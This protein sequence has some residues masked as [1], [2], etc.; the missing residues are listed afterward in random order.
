MRESTA[1]GWVFSGPFG[2]TS[3]GGQSVNGGGLM[4]GDT[5][6]MREPNFDKL[7]HKLIVVLLLLILT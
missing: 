2:G 5:D 7:C 6:L 4:R 3:T 1:G